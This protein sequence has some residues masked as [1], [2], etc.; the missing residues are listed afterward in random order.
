VCY[1]VI[2]ENMTREQQEE[3]D[4]SLVDA[5]SEEARRERAALIATLGGSPSPP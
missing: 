4:A 3:F 2:V 5:N 1:F